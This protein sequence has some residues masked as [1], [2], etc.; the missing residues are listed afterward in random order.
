VILFA[1]LAMKASN[2]D[3][4]PAPPVMPQPCHQRAWPVLALV[5]L[6]LAL[7]IACYYAVIWTWMRLHPVPVLLATLQKDYQPGQ[8]TNG[9]RFLW[10]ARGP[11]GFGSNYVELQWD[12]RS[13]GPDADP[14]YPSPPPGRYLRFVGGGGHPGQGSAQGQDLGNT[15]DRYAIVAF[16]VPESG[17]YSLSPIAA[18]HAEMPPSAAML[19]CGYL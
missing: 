17:S 3:A 18:S 5:I 7:G 16:T 13:Y 15:L 19:T 2:D 12:G 11:I 4:L 14:Q 8:L 9:W 10:N 1:S 6:V